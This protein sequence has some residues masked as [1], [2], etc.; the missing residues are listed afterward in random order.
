MNKMK[1]VLGLVI[2]LCLA[3]L[4]VISSTDLVLKEQETPIY[5]ISI[6]FNDVKDDYVQNYKKGIEQTF[7]EWT[8]DI[9]YVTLYDRNDAAQQMELIERE[10]ENGADAI[11]L[12][13]VKSESMAAM[14]EKK[15]FTTPIV[16]V[17]AEMHSEK[18][19]S[20]IHGDPK[21]SGA[22]MALQ[23]A[24]DMGSKKRQVYL[25]M[26]QQERGDSMALQAE[27]ADCFA[28]EQI[29]YTSVLYDTEEEL[30]ANIKEIYKTDR[31]ACFVSMDTYTQDTILSS[32]TMVENS[33]CRFYSFGVTDRILYYVNNGDI[34]AAVVN[35]D[36]DMGYLS[37]K[38]A[39]S[40]LRKEPVLTDITVESILV[41]KNQVYDKKHEKI[42]FPIE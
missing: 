13:P 41:N 16:C 36:F 14:L 24:A 42:L 9:N 26:N 11:I 35:N 6:I 23:I 7:A 15:S 31:R 4:F 21:K 34:E 33:A 38:T 25:L 28:A 3:A 40:L 29:P 37:M 19:V 30:A 12:F 10:I 8:T 27:M 5:H 20:S 1:C 18:I 17:G 22:L 32:T 39:I 2:L